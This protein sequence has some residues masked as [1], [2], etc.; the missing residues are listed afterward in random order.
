[1]NYNNLDLNLIKVF[2]EVY[3]SNS[4]LAA[5]KKLYISQPAVSGSIKKLEAFLGGKLFVR[6][7]RGVVPTTEGKQFYIECEETLKKLGNSINNFTKY[8]NLEKGSI[9][10]GSSSTIMR[11]ILLPFIA[12]F[13]K[14][15]PNIVITVTDAIS[16]RLSKNLKQGDID[17]AITSS[18]A[19]YEE[20]FNKTLLTKTTD[21]FIAPINF[22]KDFLTKEELKDHCLILQKKPSNNRDYFEKLCALNEIKLNPK[23][24]IGS[25][26]LITDFVE[27]KMGIAFTTKDFVLKDINSG[28]VKE[29]KTDFKIASRDVVVLTNKVNVNSFASQTFI[30]ELKEYF[31]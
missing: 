23:Y 31:K 3:N 28:R 17:I 2:M 19:L 27:S 11:R 9:N 26:G 13:T 4:I 24:E 7:P 25:F 30:N 18:P 15:H 12:K 5:S 1:M 8:T 6:K 14:K 10:I 21:C 20:I 22:E 16:T 29:L